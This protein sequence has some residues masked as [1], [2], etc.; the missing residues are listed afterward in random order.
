MPVSHLAEIIELYGFNQGID[1][2]ILNLLSY[3]TKF[4]GEK[5]F[6]EK[7]DAV[8]TLNN[9][10]FLTQK[11]FFARKDERW[12][13]YIPKW[14]VENSH[15]AFDNIAKLKLQDEV[16]PQN[17]DFDALVVFGANKSEMYRRLKY[18]K[19]LLQNNIVEIPKKIYLL[20][21]ARELH[22]RIDGSASA[23][24]RM[25]GIYGEIVFETDLFSEMYDKIL[26]KLYPQIEK[27]KVHTPKN[28]HRRPNTYD[29]I[30]YLLNNYS[31]FENKILFV[32]RAPTIFE[33]K[34]SV[35]KAL[36]G[37]NLTYE[38][39]GGECI[40]NEVKNEAKAAYHLL[41]SFAGGLFESYQSVFFSL[42]KKYHY[43]YK[44]EDFKKFRLETGYRNQ[45]H[46]PDLFS[47]VKFTDH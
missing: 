10:I 18:V 37:S 2:P 41:M 22:P 14:I 20:S 13:L 23:I 16:K 29:T 9:F 11:Y 31:L 34:A 32:S 12:D 42:C 15:N 36:S 35:D 27:I 4:Y 44:E 5:D 24:N 28:E 3:A 45:K 25:K 6:S 46:S 7:E 8:Q 21:G 30:I 40:Y 43:H 47:N 17:R 1:K 19:H 26:G 39:V 33:Q 38:V